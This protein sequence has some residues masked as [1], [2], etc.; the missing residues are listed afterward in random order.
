[1]PCGLE[2]T[3]VAPINKKN[4]PTVPDAE[5]TGK[6]NKNKK[7]NIECVLAER[8]DSQSLESS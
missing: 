3:D 5:T 6:K 2:L 7:I 1:M 4:I 8:K